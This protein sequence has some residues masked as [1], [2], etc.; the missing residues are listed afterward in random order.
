MSEDGFS[1]N[2]P[3]SGA[4]RAPFETAAA[5]P[6][7]GDGAGTAVTPRDTHF[8]HPKTGAPVEYGPAPICT[9]V[10]CIFEE[11]RRARGMFKGRNNNFAALIEEVGEFAN[12][13]LEHSFGKGSEEAV[14]REGVQVAAM[15][16]RVIEEG[17]PEFPYRG[18][19]TPS[20]S[21]LLERDIA[22]DMAA[23][24]AAFALWPRAMQERF[25]RENRA[26]FDQQGEQAP[27]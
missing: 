7:Q 20:A 10:A 5:P 14:F 26:R 22:A 13:L 18:A 23:A 25:L 4:A 15:A 19:R 8:A 11:V 27:A 1:A 9:T 24:S 17:S 2:D 21:D 12:A 3:A 6:P 16:I